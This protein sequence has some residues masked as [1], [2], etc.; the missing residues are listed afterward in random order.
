M[1]SYQEQNWQSLGVG[2]MVAGGVLGRAQPH[3]LPPEMLCLMENQPKS[4]SLGVGFHQVSPNALARRSWKG[5]CVLSQPARM[6]N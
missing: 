2:V 3:A 5:L 4:I 1:Q 6:V